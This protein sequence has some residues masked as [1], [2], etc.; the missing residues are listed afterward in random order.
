[1][2]TVL[3]A[4]ALIAE[5]NREPGAEQVLAAYP[6]V[7]IS[8]VNVAEV[9]A[10]LS[11]RGATDAETTEI[12]ARMRCPVQAFDAGQALLAGQL[13]SRTRAFGL[14]L[15]DRACLALALTIAARQVLTTDRAWQRLDLGLDI[16][17]IR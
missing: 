16:R 4:A 10:K 9:I 17:V 3:D 8:A 13:R 11:E 14:S 5:F 6:D 7:V 1:M 2:T 15:G 12:L